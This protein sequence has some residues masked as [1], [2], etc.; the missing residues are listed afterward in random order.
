MCAARFG[1]ARKDPAIAPCAHC[2]TPLPEGATACPSCGIDVLVGGTAGDGPFARGTVLESRYRIDTEVGRGGMG[3]VYRGT[4]LTLKR[5]VA[6][7]AL[8]QV[9]ADNTVLSRF[10]REARS[11]ARVEHPGLVPVYAVGREDGTYYMVMKFVEGETLQSLIKRS[12]ALEPRQIRRVMR[13]TCEALGALHK[14]GLIHRDLKPGNIML[15]A[16]GR[17]VVMDLGIVKAVGE[18][19]QTTSTAL[20]T[21]KYMAPETLTDTQVDPRAD[22]YSLGVIGYEML[23]GDPPFDGPTPMAIL[24][25]QAHEPPEPLRKR[26]PNAP[27]NLASAVERALS[28]LPTDRF[29]SAAEM[30][31][32]VEEDAA[33]T[34]AARSPLDKRTLT[35]WAV[36]AG[37]V[38]VGLVAFFASRGPDAPAPPTPSSGAPASTPA[39]VSSAAPSSAPSVPPTNAPTQ[40]AS[41]APTA[42]P[43]APPA[44]PTT[45]A[46]RLVTLR[47]TS[48]PSGALVF[49]RAAA[50][51]RTPLVLR[52]PA[53]PRMLTLTLK[54]E[55]YGDRAVNANL[56]NDG[57]VHARL[58]SLFELVP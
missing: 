27:R 56:A 47:V 16:E 35:R 48:D 49:E 8:R 33:A 5:P 9:D 23:T 24:F 45:A 26:A 44:E 40:P 36:T 12:G 7:K 28:K 25:K 13:E 31:L 55:G 41:E 22:L 32:A 57:Q 10:L 15:S 14:H 58:E 20:G 38:V 43:T 6:I 19:T 17:V 30:A 18:N 21:P 34:S 29:E 54:R 37:V 4:D 39:A 46:V 2:A 3:I 11:L 52:R 51:G 42:P 50:L 1:Y 53:A